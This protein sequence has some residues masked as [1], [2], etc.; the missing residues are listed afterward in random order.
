VY[1]YV[2]AY[3]CGE[4]PIT[5]KPRASASKFGLSRFVAGTCMCVRVCERVCV[6]YVCVCVRVC[7]FVCMCVFM[8]TCL[9]IFAYL[10]GIVLITFKPGAAHP[11][12][13]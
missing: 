2:C 11:N 9:C 7:V 3:L 1:V 12:C 6:V 5:F 8:C 10:C 13:V 4:E